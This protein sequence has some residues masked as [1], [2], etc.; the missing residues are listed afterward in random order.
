M[1]GTNN[2]SYQGNDGVMIRIFILF[3][4]FSGHKIAVIKCK[5]CIFHSTLVI[6]WLVYGSDFNFFFPGLM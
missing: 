1:R 5:Q 3:Q 6:D 4:T 2:A